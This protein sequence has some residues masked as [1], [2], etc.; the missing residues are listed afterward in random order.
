MAESAQSINKNEPRPKKRRRRTYILIGILGSG[1]ILLTA[2][3]IWGYLQ[4]QRPLPSTDGEIPV[5]Y[6][7]DGAS[8]VRDSQ[9]VPHI[10]ADNTFDLYFAQGFATAQDRLFQMDM[11]RRQASGTLSEVVG[12][13]ALETDKYFRTFGLRRAAEASLEEYDDNTIS[14]LQAYTEGVNAFMERAVREQKL[15]VEFRILGFQPDTWTPLDSLTIGK[16]MAYDLGGKWEGQAFRHWAASKFPDEK[17]EDLMPAYPADGPNVLEANR[18][19][20]VNVAHHFQDIGPLIPPPDHGSNNWVVSGEH[21]KSG[22]PLLANDPHLSLMTPSI[23]YES[24]LS[25]PDHQV[26]GVVFP[27]VPGIV[28]GHNEHVAWGVTNVSPDVQDVFL[29]QRNEDNPHEFLYDGEY[30]EATVI[31]EEIFVDDRDEPVIHE[32]VET[33]RG[34]LISEFAYPEDAEGHPP[35]TAL[36][37]KWT[38]HDATA[39]LAAVL[40]F[41]RAENWEEF[42]EALR[43]F[44]APAQNFVFADTEGNIAYRANGRIPIRSQGEGLLPKPGWDPDYGWD[45]YIPWDE[46]PTII[47]PESGM[48]STANNRIDDDDYTHHLTHSWAQ[49]FRHSRIL[50]VLDDGDNFTPEDMQALQMDTKNLQAEELLPLLTEAVQNASAEKRAEDEEALEVL[51]SWDFYDDRDKAG[52]AVFHLWRL[53][54]IDILFADEMNEDLLELFSGKE[55]IVDNMIRSAADGE[56]GAWI[57]ARGGLEGLALESLQ[58]AIDEGRDELGASPSDWEWGDFHQVT[59]EHPL[60]A[61]PPLNYLFNPGTQPMDGSPITVQAAGYDDEAPGEVA[62]AAGWRGVM[63]LNDL[64]ESYHS[65]APGQSGHRFSPWYDDQIDD[66]IEG[67]YHSTS[68]DTNDDAG[69]RLELFPM[70]GD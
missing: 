56:P 28:V 48:I 62:T 55:G 42:E 52:P 29:E 70:G 32:V 25:G 18:E 17:V 60:G 38:A 26:T 27:G 6:M 59:F 43:S 68:M 61:V 31:E 10:E 7:E 8:I 23:W 34:P 47:N 9:G 45:D 54:L 21:T 2:S 30:E 39:E 1:I 69:G 67:N 58:K 5:P 44:E 40:D 57:A 65:V 37:M 53:A 16:M 36:S 46:L 20:S 19:H 41:N 33:R 12:E 64:S 51:A 15:P 49:P 22:E 11:S 50:E 35:E 24:H 13:D 63:D 3:I 14:A 4:M 66:W